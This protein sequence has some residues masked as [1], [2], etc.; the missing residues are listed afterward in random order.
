MNP[1]WSKPALEIAEGLFSDKKGIKDIEN[2]VVSKIKSP[3][4]TEKESSG[5]LRQTKESTIDLPNIDSVTGVVITGSPFSGA[6][7]KRDLTKLGIEKEGKG[8]LLPYWQKDLVEYIKESREKNKPILGICFGK[9]EIVEALGGK[10]QEMA[11]HENGD[12]KKQVGYA[13]IYKTLEAET[14]PI[15][16]DLP[17]SFVVVENHDRETTHV[18]EGA[19]ILAVDSV[20]SVQ[21]FRVGNNIWGVQ[22]HPEKNAEDAEKILGKPENKGKF[23]PIEQEQLRPEFDQNVGKQVLQ[24]FTRQVFLNSY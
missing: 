17:G 11:K 10:V 18:P 16:K 21:A 13:R 2:L 24:N 6:L 15:F 22:F 23:N 9:E 19:K 8:V 7:L 20:G 3:A 5:S 1:T 12:R 14:D 4:L